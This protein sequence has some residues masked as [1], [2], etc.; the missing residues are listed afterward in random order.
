MLELSFIIQWLFFAYMSYQIGNRLNIKKSYPWYII[1]LWNF[2]ILGK[3]SEIKIKKISLVLVGILVM[4]LIFVLFSTYTTTTASSISIINGANEETSLFIANH[5]APPLLEIFPLMALLMIKFIGIPIFWGAVARKMGK[6]YGVYV[7]LGLFSIYLPPLLLAFERI[8][9][10]ITHSSIYS[11]L[12]K[13]AQKL[14][15]RENSI[16]I[17]KMNRVIS[18]GVLVLILLSVVYTVNL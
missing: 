7:L 15:V 13:E 1:P 9:K 14:L 10:L 16:P 18:I 12:S 6:E 17:E 3:N 5:L 11:P 8:D 4:A 2:W